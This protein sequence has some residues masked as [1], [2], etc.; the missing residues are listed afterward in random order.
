MKSWYWR[1]KA[2]QPDFFFLAASWLG[3]VL[4]QALRRLGGAQPLRRI[5]LELSRDGFRGQGVPGRLMLVATVVPSLLMTALAP[6]G[7]GISLRE[8]A[9]IGA[10]GLDRLA[11]APENDPV[12][13]RAG[14]GCG[15]DHGRMDDRPA[16]LPLGTQ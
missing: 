1:T 16:A 11:F 6:G 9:A 13:I 12:G 14:V 8:I 3:A 4:L 15:V 7:T 2:C 5:D 10:P